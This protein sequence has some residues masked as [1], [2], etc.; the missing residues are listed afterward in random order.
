MARNE[1]KPLV[2]KQ[3]EEQVDAMI[4]QELANYIALRGLGK[5]KGKKRGAKKG[6]KGKKAKVKKIKLPGGKQIGGFTDYELL[7]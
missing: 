2:E 1:I 6:K 3:L 5:K 7:C 4:K